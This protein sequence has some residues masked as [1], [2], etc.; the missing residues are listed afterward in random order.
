MIKC[1][2]NDCIYPEC[3]R[4]CGMSDPTLIIH[5]ARELK[6][7]K[8]DLHNMK[9]TMRQFARGIEKLG[10][11]ESYTPTCPFNNK[12]CILDPAYAKMYHK[13][14]WIKRGMPIMCSY[15]EEAAE[16]CTCECCCEETTEE[17]TCECCCEETAEEDKAE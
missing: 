11:E 5:L 1:E 4:T 6:Q 2:Y 15:C 13:E 17:C 14:Y 9:F 16:E 7:V 3:N 8:L 12:D 10:H